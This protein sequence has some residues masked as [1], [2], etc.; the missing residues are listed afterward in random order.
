MMASMTPIVNPMGDAAAIVS[1][2]ADDDDVAA[3]QVQNLTHVLRLQWHAGYEAIV[4]AFASV[5]L[6]YSP[7][8]VTWDEVKD[9]I[10][11][12]LEC[13]R[14]VTTAESR[15]VEIPVCYSAELA[16][17]LADVAKAHGLTVEQTIALH[18]EAN[19]IVRM[20]GFSPG[21]PYLAGLPVELT[22]PRRATPRLKVPAGSV[23]I[24]GRQTG[25]YSLETPGGWQ[26]I[27]RTPM[28]M[29][30]PDLN[31][32]CL[33]RAGDHVSFVP[34]SADQFRSWRAES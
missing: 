10:R 29:F 24:G 13:G 4:P 20:I 32:P 27:G 2:P 31:P 15:C 14:K 6:H 30:R 18:S 34:I 12:A 7:L 1:W 3:E 17:D 21:F 9:H 25:I 33:L 22:T 19:Y 11:R 16:T 8:Q 23:A 28:A 5:T 26:I